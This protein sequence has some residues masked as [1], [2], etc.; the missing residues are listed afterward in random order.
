M[1]SNPTPC[2]WFNNCS[3]EAVDYY[4]SVFRHSKIIRIDYYTDVGE[5]VT[6][7]K[8]GDV[9]AIE[10]KI[11]NTKF[12]ALNAG[13]EF[14]FNPSVSFTIECSSQKEIDYYWDRLSS[15][16]DAEQ[17]GW[18]Q[19][20]FGVSWQVV[21]KILAKMLKKGTEEQRT[22]VTEAYFQMKKFDIAG[23]KAAYTRT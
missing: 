13:P 2:L 12:I 8:K 22:R 11:R 1:I 23:L 21:P 14:T 19:D 7:H 17:C 18:L 16:P 3:R 9:V 10:F 15:D 20:K 6:G 4:V 5:A